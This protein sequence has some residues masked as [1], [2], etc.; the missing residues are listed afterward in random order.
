[1]LIGSRQLYCAALQAHCGPQAHV[2]PQAQ[3]RQLAPGQSV[4]WHWEA[5][6]KVVLS[7]VMRISCGV[8]AADSANPW[9]EFWSAS[10]FLT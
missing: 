5:A 7:M 6:A 2:G 8:E 1:M 10:P 3:E 9:G 4:H